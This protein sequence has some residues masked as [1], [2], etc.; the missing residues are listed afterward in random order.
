MKTRSIA[1]AAHQAQETTTIARCWRF[2]RRD[3]EVY[4]LTDH[5]ADVEVSGEVYAAP[6]GLTPTAISQEATAA[7]ANSEVSGFLTDVFTEEDIRAG[8][9]DSA[10]FTIFEVNYADV[11]QGVMILAAGNFGEFTVT[12]NA[13]K[14]EMR[15]LTQ[16]LQK[17]NGRIVTKGCPWRFGDPDTCRVDLDP[18]T[19]TGAV[20]GVTDLRTFASADRSEPDDYFGAGVVTFTSGLNEGLSSEIY[21]YDGAGNFVLYLPMPYLIEVGDTYSMVPGCRKRF[22]EDCIAKWAN[23]NNF[24]GFPLLPGPD[25]VLGLGGTEGS[26]L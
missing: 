20:T 15:G 16:S 25:K 3:G 1:L 5:D 11:S 6:Q 19:V 12:R 24:G 10:F 4:T 18:L 7:V 26:N 2:E 22:Q 21:S 13:F 8:R 23:G 17:V 14:A 9:W